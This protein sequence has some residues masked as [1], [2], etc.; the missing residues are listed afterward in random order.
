MN[1]HED[2]TVVGNNVSMAKG[3]EV[4]ELYSAHYPFSRERVPMLRILGWGDNCYVVQIIN[5]SEKK[6]K[7][8]AQCDYGDRSYGPYFTTTPDH[9]GQIDLCRFLLKNGVGGRFKKWLQAIDSNNTA[10][11]EEYRDMAYIRFSLELTD[12]NEE[13]WSIDTTLQNP[14]AAEQDVA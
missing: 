10:L 11:A 7:V 12:A 6:G 1:T 2:K 9:W 3:K 5:F 8:I 4:W 13:E 14:A